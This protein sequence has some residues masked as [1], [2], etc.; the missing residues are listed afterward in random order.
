MHARTERMI[1]MLIASVALFMFVATLRTT[2]SRLS[3]ERERS[4]V[5]GL[6]SVHQGRDGGLAGEMER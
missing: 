1:W 6:V 3:L 5:I 4:A 2:E